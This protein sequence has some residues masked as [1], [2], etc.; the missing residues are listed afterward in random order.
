MAYLP[1]I[2]GQLLLLNR[3]AQTLVVESLNRKPTPTSSS[4]QVKWRLPILLSDHQ[5][6]KTWLCQ[7]N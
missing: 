7:Y 3:L 2:H 6:R 4:V 5:S 1:F